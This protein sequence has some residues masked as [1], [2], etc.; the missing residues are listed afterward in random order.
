M[1]LP[2][3]RERHFKKTGTADGDSC[4]AL[5][6]IA[7]P[8]F[9]NSALSQLT[10]LESQEIQ[11]SVKSDGIDRLLGIG[12]NLRFGVESDTESRLG[13]HRKII[14][15]VT[16]GNRLREV[17]LLRLGYKPQKNFR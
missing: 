7:E 14:G 11:N 13:N 3:G 16:H 15:S 2:E 12:D 17:D 5:F 9:Q 4:F 6:R 8:S 10:V 1:V